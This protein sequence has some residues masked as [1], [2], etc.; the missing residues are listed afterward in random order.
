MELSF[1]LSAQDC[2]AW[3]AIDRRVNDELDVRLLDA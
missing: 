1:Q 3:S 2:G